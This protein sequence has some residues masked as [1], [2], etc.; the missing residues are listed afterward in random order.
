MIGKLICWFFGHD[1]R[2]LTKKEV[3][4]LQALA[5][6]TSHNQGLDRSLSARKRV[7]RRCDEERFTRPRRTKVVV[8]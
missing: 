5:A 7:C 6:A 3:E 8:A 2:R 4:D 1:E